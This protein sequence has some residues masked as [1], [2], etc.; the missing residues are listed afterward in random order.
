M[1]IWTASLSLPHPRRLLNPWTW[2]TASPS[3]QAPELEI[4]HHPMTPLSLTPISSPAPNLA[5]PPSDTVGKL[6]LHPAWPCIGL[7]S[8]RGR[9]CRL[10]DQQGPG[11]T[12]NPAP[13]S[14]RTPSWEEKT[15]KLHHD[16]KLP[17]LLLEA[18]S[19]PFCARPSHTLLV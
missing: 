13:T 4:L 6:G 1:K 11:S 10:R 8:G 2:L 15:N 7:A 14:H 12:A 17:A 5:D 16:S 18:S 3:T 19:S 9:L